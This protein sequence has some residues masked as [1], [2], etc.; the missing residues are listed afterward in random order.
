MQKMSAIKCSKDCQISWAST[1]IFDLWQVSVTDYFSMGYDLRDN[2]FVPRTSS[3]LLRKVE[4]F[5]EIHI[6]IKG[7]INV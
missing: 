7:E 5:L 2:I 3:W 6:P 1:N 4:S